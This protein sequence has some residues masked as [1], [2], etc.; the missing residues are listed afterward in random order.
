[1]RFLGIYVLIFQKRSMYTSSSDLETLRILQDK[2]LKKKKNSY[3]WLLLNKYPLMFLLLTLETFSKSF[4]I[5]KMEV[6]VEI[7]NSWNPLTILTISS[8]SLFDRFIWIRLGT[9]SVIWIKNRWIYQWRVVSSKL[10][11]T[12]GIFLL[13]VAILFHKFLYPFHDLP[14]QFHGLLN[15][16]SI[17][18]LI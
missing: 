11:V 15:Y 3:G 7:V 16:L 2:Y 13:Q 10:R 17:C 9:S 1:M 14:H 4:L 12:S 18:S 5:S 8:L 6:F